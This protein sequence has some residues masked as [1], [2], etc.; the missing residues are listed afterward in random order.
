MIRRP[1]LTLEDKLVFASW[2][3]ITLRFKDEIIR[4]WDLS[5]QGN[6][7]QYLNYWYA[8]KWDELVRS[9]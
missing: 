1:P 2:H 5:G 7:S 6:F 4:E 9:N 8:R 3:E